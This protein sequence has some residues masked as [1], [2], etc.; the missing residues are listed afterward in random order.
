MSVSSSLSPYH[1]LYTK[2]HC[3]VNDL[4]VYS[5]KYVK[6]LDHEHTIIKRR[7]AACKPITFV[8]CGL[9]GGHTIYG[10]GQ[11]YRAGMVR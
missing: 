3:V 11:M 9:A 2:N 7:H 1:V 4:S 10:F 6:Q 8:D 5:V